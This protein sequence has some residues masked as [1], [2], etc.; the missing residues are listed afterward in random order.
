MTLSGENDYIITQQIY[1]II[2]D[3]VITYI[4]RQ[5]LHYQALVLHYQ[6]VI[7]GTGNYYVISCITA[8]WWHGSRQRN[9]IVTSRML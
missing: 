6:A 4:I 5:L 2:T 9:A 1:Y 3:D 8:F 7:I